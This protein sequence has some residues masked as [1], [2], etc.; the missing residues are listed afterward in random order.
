MKRISEIT[1]TYDE[2]LL[3]KAK[4]LLLN[5]KAQ[6]H[7]YTESILFDS[8]HSATIEGARTTIEQVRKSLTN[9]KTKSDKMVANNV[10]VLNYVYNGTKITDDNIRQLWE[11]L[12]H[13]C[14][15]NEQLAGTKYRSGMVYIGSATEIV[16]V[17]AK[18]ED[19][20]EYMTD[21]F[22][23]LYT[24]N[25][26]DDI[27]KAIVGHIY[28]V[29]IHPF[30]DGNG[31]MARILMNSLLFQSGYTN[32]KYLNIS[33]S[34]RT[35]LSMYYKT[36]LLSEHNAMNISPFVD[37]MLKIIVHACEEQLKQQYKLSDKEKILISK[38]KTDITVKKAAQ[39]L[40]TSEAVARDG[41][42]KLTDKGLL[43]KRKEHG[44]SIYSKPITF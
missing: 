34:I 15:E 22:N 27:I 19:I 13:G 14:C 8:F 43:V 38:I 3:Q 10:K 2:N 20:Q 23:W 30:C 32:V 5:I 39:M 41:L 25:N 36:M 33:A 17:P 26:E 18:T 12:V 35:Y 6:K 24:K 21:L 44:K 1:Y 9:P 40:K 11:I 28:F 4:K 29:Y 16:H 37:Y 31:R 42:N 7:T